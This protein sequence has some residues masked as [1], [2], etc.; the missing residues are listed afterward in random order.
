M[1]A[2]HRDLVA[3]VYGLKYSISSSCTTERC[4]YRNFT[5]LKTLEKTEDY[6]IILIQELQQRHNEPLSTEKGIIPRKYNPKFFQI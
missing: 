3:E 4:P 2:I 5:T 6:E 1:H